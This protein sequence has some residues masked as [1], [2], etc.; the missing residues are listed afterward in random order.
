MSIYKCNLDTYE[1]ELKKKFS[2][3]LYAVG[4]I[5]IDDARGNQQ[6]K[7]DY[8]DICIELSKY[9]K[10]AVDNNNNVDVD[11]I[12]TSDS[13]TTYA[14]NICTNCL[15]S[16]LNLI[17]FNTYTYIYVNKK[18]GKNIE[19]LKIIKYTADTGCKTYADSADGAPQTAPGTSAGADVDTSECENQYDGDTLTNTDENKNREKHESSEF[20]TD[21][22]N[23]KLCKFL[24]K[25][26]CGYKLLTKLADKNFHTFDA[27]SS[28]ID[29]YDTSDNNNKKCIFYMPFNQ[30]QQVQQSPAPLG[31]GYTMSAFAPSPS[32]GQHR[33][34]MHRDAQHHDKKYKES[35]ALE[36]IRKYQQKKAKLAEIADNIKRNYG[37]D[38]P[39]AIPHMN[40]VMVM[41]CNLA[42]EFLLKKP[43][44]ALDTINQHK[45]E[46][47]DEQLM[48]FGRIAPR[49]M[50][51]ILKD[52]KDPHAQSKIIA[53]LARAQEF[54]K[55]EIPLVHDHA[56]HVNNA[57]SLIIN[58]IMKDIRNSSRPQEKINPYVTPL[59]KKYR[60]NPDGTPVYQISKPSDHTSVVQPT[61]VA[62][63]SVARTPVQSTVVQ[64]TPVALPQKSRGN[65]FTTSGGAVWSVM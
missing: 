31:F 11:N 23:E 57:S 16:M 33:D 65:L 42:T 15:I 51:G 8:I 2:A 25:Y 56:K 1:K 52:I 20:I 49:D 29:G 14:D 21:N 32:G 60:S 63:T 13:L 37:I 62:Q 54:L 44:L 38:H 47:S 4:D 9:F 34:V 55:G 17:L 6:Y 53:E 10:I 48:Q 27:Y 58:H 26:G 22:I 64:Q 12:I 7:K 19:D 39:K 45:Y 41:A 30:V 43:K 50:N 28:I 35:R 40:Q 3:S 61:P 59:S 5:S 46:I 24:C 36:E 18:D